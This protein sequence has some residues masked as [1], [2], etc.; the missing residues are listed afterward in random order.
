L[1]IKVRPEIAEDIPA[2]YRVEEAAFGRTSEADLVDLC[3]THGKAVLS[4]VAVEGKQV[5]GHLLFT[6]VT[7]DPP[8][9][10]WHGLGIGPVA[11]LP[12]FQRMGIGSRLMS[13]GLEIC[14]KQGYDFIVLLGDPAYYRHFGF[15]PGREFGLSSDYGDG[16]NFQARELTPGVLRGAKAV[17]KYVPE[18]KEAGC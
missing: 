2:I 5:T 8:H 12:E 18:F 16:D 1:H 10:G 6:P 11:V 7:L 3:R 4:M 17:V 13:I 14:R 15:I 9:P